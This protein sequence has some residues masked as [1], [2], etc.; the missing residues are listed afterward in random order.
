MA[1]IIII[2]SMVLLGGVFLFLN[3]QP[4]PDIRRRIKD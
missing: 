4:E 2:I 3:R 1:N